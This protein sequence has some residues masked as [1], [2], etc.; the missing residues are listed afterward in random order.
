MVNNKFIKKFVFGVTIA[1]VC[2]IS[3]FVLLLSSGQS[4]KTNQDI[5]KTDK[6]SKEYVVDFLKVYFTKK[7]P[8]S[9]RSEYKKYMTTSAYNHEVMLEEEPM[10]KYRIQNMRNF[11]YKS[12]KTYL[13]QDDN[14]VYVTAKY[15]YDAYEK[16]PDVTESNKISMTNEYSLKLSY[17]RDKESGK[18]LINDCE[19]VSLDPVENH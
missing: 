8:G 18:W 5:S 9:N 17:K 14:V 4:S 13:G 2:L 1:V 7:K 3:I 12:S 19:V 16:D 11:K 10:L 15:S 6:V